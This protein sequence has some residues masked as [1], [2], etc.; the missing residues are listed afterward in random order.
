M[1]VRR[2]FLLLIDALYRL[3][4]NTMN[5]T[6]AARTHVP[7]AFVRLSSWRSYLTV[8]LGRRASA[9]QG[10]SSARTLCAVRASPPRACVMGGSSKRKA[11]DAAPAAGEDALAEA[12]E[13]AKRK[14][15]ARLQSVWREDTLVR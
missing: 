6:A 3:Y 14:A 8:L 11:S 7:F 2:H 15:E 13:T 9:L 12:V 10:N 4:N 5:K 1:Y